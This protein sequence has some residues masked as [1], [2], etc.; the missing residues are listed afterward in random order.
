MDRRRQ[1]VYSSYA[2]ALFIYGWS[3]VGFT[4]IILIIAY[5]LDLHLV[6]EPKNI[7]LFV[8]GIN[9]FIGLI[10]GLVLVL[11]KNKL[12]RQ[13]KTHYRSEFI[14][15]VFISAFSIL[16]S[17]VLFDYLGGNRDYIANILVFLA[18]LILVILVFVGKKFFKL[19]LVSRK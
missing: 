19:N 1:K 11:Q 3:F 12:K 4:P 2:I 14:L 9:I 15:I 18:A 13:V 7:I 5:M 6:Y 10:S 16:G 8:L 17:V